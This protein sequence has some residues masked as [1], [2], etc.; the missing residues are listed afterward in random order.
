MPEKSGME[1]ALRVPLPAGPAAGDTACAQAGVE[2]ADTIVTN[3]RKSRRCTFMLPSVS[4]FRRRLSD[5][6]IPFVGVTRRGARRL[7]L[8]RTAVFAMG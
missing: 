1:A 3:K 4:S 5:K 7:H 8:A 6:A 2:I